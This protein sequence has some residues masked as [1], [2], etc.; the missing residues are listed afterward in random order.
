MKRICSPAH[1]LMVAGVALLSL[2]AVAAK[3]PREEWD[4]LQRV[5]IKG[6][7]S[8]YVRPGADFT[9]YNK[10]IIDPIQVAFH[11]DWDKKSTYYNQ[12]LPAEKL[13]QIKSSLGKLA[14]ETFADVFSKDG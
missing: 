7:D 6:I 4:G 11:K 3:K 12:K 5:K 13:E 2:V 10:I 9:I 1:V 14:E 8:A